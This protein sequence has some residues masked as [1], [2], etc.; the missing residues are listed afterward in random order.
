MYPVENV[1]RIV[2]NDEN[3]YFKEKLRGHLILDF[4]I[5]VMCGIFGRGEYL[6]LITTTFM[7]VVVTM[8]LGK[9]KNIKI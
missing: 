2:D 9:Y 8:V 5:G 7:M 6:L 1:N 3:V 4:L